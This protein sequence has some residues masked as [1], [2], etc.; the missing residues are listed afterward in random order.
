MDLLM[1]GRE[2]RKGKEEKGQGEIRG[3]LVYLH[4]QQLIFNLRYLQLP[5]LFP[6]L[7]HGCFIGLLQISDLIL[8]VAIFQSNIHEGFLVA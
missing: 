4:L 1:M 7:A 8:N 6:Q 3:L 2:R 5:L